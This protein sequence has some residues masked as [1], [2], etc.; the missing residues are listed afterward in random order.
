MTGIAL[1]GQTDL[2]SNIFPYS[3]VGLTGEKMRERRMIQKV[4]T[5]ASHE[6]VLQPRHRCCM[7][8]VLNG[9]IDIITL[10]SNFTSSNIPL[11]VRLCPKKQVL[12]TKLDYVG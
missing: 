11:E 1:K 12:E 2:N 4:L 7:T 8:Y 3:G 9:T 10:K 5:I 6:P